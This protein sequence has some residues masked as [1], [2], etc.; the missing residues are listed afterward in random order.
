MAIQCSFQQDSS[1][2]FSQIA[3]FSIVIV[4]VGLLIWDRIRYDVVAL[5]ALLAAIVCG[6]VP[7]E[8]AFSGFS[9]DIV[10]IVG[11]A[12][13]V[14]AAVGRSG[15]VELMMRPFIPHMKTTGSQVGILVSVVT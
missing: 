13:V 1:M 2:T 3:A 5:G 12:L 10:I 8:K 4:M 7:P 11:S 6:I 15:I 9:D 14:S